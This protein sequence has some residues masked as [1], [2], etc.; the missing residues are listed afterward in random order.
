MEMARCLR[1][2]LAPVRPFASETCCPY[3]TEK[4]R[5]CFAAAIHY[6][7]P[8]NILA[9]L[10][11]HVLFYTGR[12]FPLPGCHAEA[13]SKVLPAWTFQPTEVSFPQHHTAVSTS[14][15]NRS[16]D[17]CKISETDA[18]Y[19]YDTTFDRSV[20]AV[21]QPFRGLAQLLALEVVILSA[22]C[23]P[24]GPQGARW[25]PCLVLVIGGSDER[26]L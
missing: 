23:T 9:F 13:F 8:T 6:R 10:L 12:T 2:H 14:V 1:S 21:V 17:T 19:T 22:I 25:R 3:S 11:A 4:Q 7:L 26:V 18:C 24:P 16:A 20:V 5:S 15:T